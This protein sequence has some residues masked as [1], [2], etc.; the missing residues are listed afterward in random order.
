MYFQNIS[1]II[2][3]FSRPR[4]RLIWDFFPQKLRG[5]LCFF[6]FVK[7]LKLSAEG[8]TVRSSPCAS[9][10]SRSCLTPEPAAAA[11]LPVPRG[12]LFLEAWAPKLE[13]KLC[14]LSRELGS[15]GHLPM[16]PSLFSTLVTSRHVCALGRAQRKG[17][18]RCW[19]IFFF[20]NVAILA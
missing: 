4:L 6:Y 18:K 11:V 15:S 16:D 8:Y 17:K 3:T 1:C 13:V 20:F 7:M 5:Y 9:V 14:F 12:A 19:E 2:Q 10:G